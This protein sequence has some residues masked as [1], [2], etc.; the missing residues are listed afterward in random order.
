MTQAAN[1]NGI[2]VNQ[3]GVNVHR[4]PANNPERNMHLN[5]TYEEYCDRRTAMN[6]ATKRLKHGKEYHDVTYLG[7]YENPAKRKLQEERKARR[8]NKRAV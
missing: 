8:N 7:T 2:N 3:D 5:E 6:K 1:N 4:N